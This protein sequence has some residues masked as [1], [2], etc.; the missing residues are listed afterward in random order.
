MKLPLLDFIIIIA[1]I[2]FIALFTIASTT[3]KQNLEDHEVNRELVILCQ[4]NPIYKCEFIDK[5]C[6]EKIQ[7]GETCNLP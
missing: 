6:R 7:N 5:L 3:S 2:A 4:D 1:I